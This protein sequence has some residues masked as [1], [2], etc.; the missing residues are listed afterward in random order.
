MLVLA[1]V[2]ACRAGRVERSCAIVV[3]VAVSVVVVV[4]AGAPGPGSSV[5]PML[6]RV[7]VRK[8][9]VTAVVSAVAAGAAVPALALAW[10]CRGR[11]RLQL[12][13]SATVALR[14][15]PALPSS[16]HDKKC[17]LAG[18]AASVVRLKSRW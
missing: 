1:L 3:A 18:G 8:A 11:C 15:T 14:C 10:R 12:V 9:S 13:A 16:R 17:R 7:G 6:P 4:A 5:L 2:P